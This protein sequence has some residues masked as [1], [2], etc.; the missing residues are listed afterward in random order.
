VVRRVLFVQGG[1]E[2]AH[3]RWDD[4]LVASLQ[5]EL[6][7][8][9]AI[10]YP[11]MPDEADPQYFAWKAA[12][13]AAFDALEDGAILVGHSVGGTIL[14]NALAEQPPRLKVGG[15][16]LIAAPFIGQ[17]GWP[18][19]DIKP[20]A[21]L[22][23][24]LPVGVPIFLYQGGEDE[25]VP[26]AHVH[27][28]AKAIPQAVIR[29]AEHSDHQLNDDLSQLA[30]DIRSLGLPLRAGGRARDAQRKNP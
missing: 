23:E 3:D 22:S 30:R 2:G 1:G 14:I 12:L 27:L 18:S 28:Y 17:G 25:T 21:N 29:I 10:G 6:G 26:I 8:D 19:A 4:K 9:Y 24:D 16:F 20:R 7:D 15:I 5:H 11:R 13:H